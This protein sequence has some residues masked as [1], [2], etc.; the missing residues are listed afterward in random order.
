MKMEG[1]LNTPWRSFCIVMAADSPE[2]HDWQVKTLNKILAE[3]GGMILRLAKTRC[4]KT[5]IS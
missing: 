5:V 1:K 2:E 3:T 4:G